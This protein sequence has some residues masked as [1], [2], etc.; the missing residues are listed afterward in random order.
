MLLLMS[1]WIAQAATFDPQM[2]WRTIQTEHFNITFHQGLEEVADT[3][4]VEVEPIYDTMVEE[5]RW[6]PR[7]RTEV[8]LVDRTDSANGYASVVPYNSI[9][10]YVTAPQ[11]D[12]SLSRYDDWSTAIMT[13]EFTHVLHMDTNHGIV[14]LARSV[15]G[16]VASTNDVSPWWM[17]EGFA[18]FQETRHTEGGRGRTP[19]ADMIK[20]TSV[21]EDAF[22][23]LGNLDGLQPKPPAGNLRYL[24]GQDFMQFVADEVGEDV[25]TKWVHTYGSWVPFWL[26]TKRVFGRSLRSLYR[27]WKVDMTQRYAEQLA[28]AEAV[29]PFSSTS[30]ISEPEASC[31]APSFSPDGGRLVWSC[32]DLRTGSAIWTANPDGSDAHVLVQDR[33]AK[34]FTWRSDGEAFVYAS[35]HTVNRFNVWSDI[36]LYTL[37][38]ERTTALT[39]GARARDPDFSP[40]GSRLVMVTNRAENNQLEVATVDRRR[41]ALTNITDNTQFSTPRFS[42]DGQMLALSAWANGRRDLWL[43]D[44]EGTPR[45]RLTADPTMDRDPIWSRDGRWLYFSSDRTGIPNIFA[46]DVVTEGLWQVTNLRTGATKPNV[47]ADG[48]TLAMQVYSQD[49]WDV[50]LM[51]LDPDAFIPW[52]RLPKTLEHSEPLAELVTPVELPVLTPPEVSTTPTTKRR[53]HRGPVGDPQRTTACSTAAAFPFTTPGVHAPRVFVDACRSQSAETVDNFDM[54]DVDEAFG[55]EED[56]DWFIEPRRYNPTRT[57]WPRYALPFLQTTQEPGRGPF[58]AL[59][60]G[61]QAS[62]ASTGADTLRHFAW[63]ANLSY[64]TDASYLG[65]GAALTFNRFLPVYSVGVNRYAVPSAQIAVQGVDD[66]GNAGVFAT[67]ETYWEARHS[68]F[69]SV[70]YPY[71]PRTTIFG[72]YTLTWRDNLFELPDDT[73]LPL[74][75]IRGRTGEL[76]GGWRYSWSQPT[77]YAISQE[78]ART[79]SVIGSVSHPLLGSSVKGDGITAS[80]DERVGLTVLQATAELRQYV[81]NPLIPNHVLAVKLGGGYTVG[82]NQFLG[83]YQLGGS[84][85]DSAFVSVPDATRMLRGYARRADVGDRYWLTSAEYR[86]PLWQIQHG[87]GT[88]PVYARN[89]SGAVFV[90]AGNAFTGA[91]ELSDAFDGTL[92]G[93]GAELTTRWAVG[94]GAFITG[95]IGYGVGLTPVP[96]RPTARRLPTDLGA[97]YLQFGGSF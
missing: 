14:R 53:P 7:A 89:L 48:K 47:S 4:A 92:V 21:V 69:V 12:S 54:T 83:N 3:F 96:D 1:T 13:H 16:R 78:D 40:D 15:V 49:G 55:N 80:P 70:S 87:F 36:Y 32:Y 91:T 26:P 35:S 61:V 51:D 68:A 94:W 59:P 93:V 10:I 81:V 58:A 24:F 73:Y 39:N 62:L 43:Y 38:N 57:L 66:E 22:P 31:G 6:V 64:R 27:D 18:T 11:E 44:L 79:V 29:A 2:T 86:L 60:F 30:V 90:D 67:D 52:G 25:W 9:V 88:L 41:V 85:G 74:V 17:V 19:F 50:H 82:A 77:A 71:R 34:N 46:I 23:P 28:A 76:A 97:W 75:P 56:I 95:R 42:P 84:V 65:G 37:E 72:R 5:V 33:G 20:R 45:R 8:V 63:S